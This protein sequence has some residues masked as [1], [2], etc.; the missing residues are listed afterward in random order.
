[1]Y[2]LSQS[3]SLLYSAYNAILF[4]S[5]LSPFTHLQGQP[6]RL[7]T[8]VRY[9]MGIRNTFSSENRKYYFFNFN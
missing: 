5:F 4:S 1:M 6:G 3:G 7:K 8:L 9:K 2:K